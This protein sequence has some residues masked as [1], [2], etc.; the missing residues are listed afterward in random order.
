MPGEINY[1]DLKTGSDFL[2]LQAEYDSS[3]NKEKANYFINKLQ[4]DI[5]AYPKRMSKGMKQK[6]RDV[7]VPH[8]LLI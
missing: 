6:M 7:S 5:S 4:L 2:K 3:F 1:P 8:F